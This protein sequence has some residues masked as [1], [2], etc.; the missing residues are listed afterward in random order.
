M[1]IDDIEDFSNT[2]EDKKCV[3]GKVL[4]M[5]EM[6]HCMECNSLVHPVMDGLTC[7]CHDAFGTKRTIYINPEEFPESWVEC[8]AMVCEKESIQKLAQPPGLCD[9]RSKRSGDQ[10]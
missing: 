9:F 3:A 7:Q 2:T 5:L 4:G 10:G 8:V 1:D 6:V